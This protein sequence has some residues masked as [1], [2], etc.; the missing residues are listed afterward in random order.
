[1]RWCI[2][3]QLSLIRNRSLFYP[4]WVKAF[5]G[6]AESSSQS[7]CRRARLVACGLPNPAAKT[8]PSFSLASK[9]SNSTWELPPLPA[10]SLLWPWFLCTPTTLEN[11][12]R[13]RE[14]VP[15]NIHMEKP[16]L[17]V[18]SLLVFFV[19][20]LNEPLIHETLSLLGTASILRDEEYSE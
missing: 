8:L 10:F 16:L 9:G 19:L 2:I 1:M 17:P 6:I 13:T 4:L 11:L 5:M 15:H 7:C 3:P 12:A 18:S 14:Q 20:Q